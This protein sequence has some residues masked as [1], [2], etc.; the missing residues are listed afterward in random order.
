MADDTQQTAFSYGWCQTDRKEGQDIRRDMRSVDYLNDEPYATRARAILQQ[1]GL[2][3]PKPEQIYRGTH[4]DLLFLNSHGVVIRI[5]PT[6][7][8]DLMNPA[9]VQP[10][11]WVEDKTLPI[12]SKQSDDAKD[13]PFTV[14]IYPGIELYEDF[15][16]K[17]PRPGIVADVEDF[18]RATG[19]S[20][21]DIVTYNMGI[22]RILDDDGIEVAVPMLLDA[23]NEFNG[24]DQILREKRSAKLRE[25]EKKT[26]DKG[27]IMSYVLKDVFKDAQDAK[28]FQ[29]AYQL[30][31]PL[32]NLFWRAFRNVEAIEDS[33]QK[34]H[35]DAFWQECA[36]ITNAPKE[37]TSFQWT[38][39][40]ND[41]GLHVFKREEIVIPNLTLYRP[42]TGEEQDKVV[43]PIAQ[44]ETVK[45]ALAKA[46]KKADKLATGEEPPKP[47]RLINLRF[48][49]DF[50]ARFR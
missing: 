34:E 25:M 33:P 21:N 8:E 6:D 31:Q 39:R 10:L 27:Q 20:A 5:G 24:S 40:V 32:R 47:R 13:I 4:H 30:H 49:N 42:W 2:P 46:A 38:S 17:T 36:A 16:Q 9:I 11:G 35:M 15:F 3:A 45:A 28:L 23:D 29:R 22:I 37:T 26:K 12:K 43:L 7:I 1:M 50:A 44:S 14:A 19:Q 18:F 48:I 41:S